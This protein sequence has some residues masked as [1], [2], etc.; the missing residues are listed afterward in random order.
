M[1][2]ARIDD[3]PVPFLPTMKLSRGPKA[4]SKWPCDLKFFR[5]VNESTLTITGQG[6]IDYGSGQLVCV[7]SRNETDLDNGAVVVPGRLPPRGRRAR[8]DRAARPLPPRHAAGAGVAHRCK[9]HSVNL[10]T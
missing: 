8:H 3:L 1:M 9:E 6:L 2:P 5:R 7:L 4:I 10:L